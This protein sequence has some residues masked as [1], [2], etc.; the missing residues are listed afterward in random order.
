MQLADF[1]AH[2][3]AELGVEVRERLVEEEDA[4]IA[5]DGA[6]HRHALSLAARQG[7]RIAVEIGRQPQHL[8]GAFHARVYFGARHLP[9]PKR[10]GHVRADGLVGVERVVLEHHRDVP[11]RGREVVHHRLVDRDG[12]AGDALEPRDHPKKRGL[13]ASRWP[14]E[15]DE[16]PIG[17]VDVEPVDHLDRA[18]ALPQIADRHLSHP[19]PRP[20]RRTLAMA[21]RAVTPRYAAARLAWSSFSP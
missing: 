5:H 19:S 2:L 4:R 21:G 9:H 20:S 8:G 1:G 18:I 10:E 13:A 3:H 7:A 12:P 6:P 15:H 14:D 17:D 11:A 16:F